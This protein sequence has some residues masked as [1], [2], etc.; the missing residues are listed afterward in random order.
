MVFREKEYTDTLYHPIHITNN[1]VI[2]IRYSYNHNLYELYTMNKE[3]YNKLIKVEN[4]DLFDELN[5]SNIEN[6]IMED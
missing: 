3:M 2:C 1:M 6:D 4:C 5:W